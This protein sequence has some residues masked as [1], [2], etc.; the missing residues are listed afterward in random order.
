MRV[1]SASDCSTAAASRACCCAVVLGVAVAASLFGGVRPA[2]SQP[3]LSPAGFALNV[4]TLL[5]ANRYADAWQLLVAVEKRAVP[6]GLYV[7]CEERSPIPGHLVRDRVT[8][9][10]RVRIAVPGLQ[11]RRLGYYVTVETTIAGLAHNDSVTTQFVFQLVSEAGQLGWTLHP[12]RFH[13]YRQGHCLQTP[14]P[15]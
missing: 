14:P 5:T 3:S 4:V 15:A 8:S 12:D 13:A 7:A 6:L 10:R 11:R 2:A 9:I 1:C